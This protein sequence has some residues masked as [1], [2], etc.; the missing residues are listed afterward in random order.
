MNLDKLDIIHSLFIRRRDADE[1]GDVKCCTC[2]ER[3]HW[4][5]MDAG[6]FIP[7]G[8]LAT[9]Y[10]ERNVHACCPVCNRLKDGNLKKYEIFLRSK[11]GQSVIEELREKSKQTIKLMQWEIDGLIKYYKIKINQLNI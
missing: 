3:G 5:T 9:R 7:R 6:H 8:K 11:Y 2:P 10:D 1:W 4:K